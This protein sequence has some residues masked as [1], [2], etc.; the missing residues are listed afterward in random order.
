MNNN[1]YL[2]FWKPDDEHGIFSN[3]YECPYTHNNILFNTSEHYLMYEKAIL[4]NDLT[5]AAKIITCDSPKRAQQLGRMI[6]NWDE[7][8]WVQNRENIMFNAL[9]AK[10]DNNPA[11]KNYLLNTNNKIL[12]EASPVDKIWG[13]GLNKHDAAKNP[14]VFKGLNL[15]GKSLMNLRDYYHLNPQ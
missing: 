15:L 13:I 12:V 3:W 6:K 2:Y 9:K 10:F 7:D 4:M 1:D 14:G 5:I 8:K 11:L